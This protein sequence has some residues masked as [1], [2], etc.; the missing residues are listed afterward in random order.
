MTHDEIH[1]RA[2]GAYLGFAIG[3]ALGATVAFMTPAEIQH[4]YGMHRDM[5]GGGWFKLEPGQITDGAQMALALGQSIIDSDGWNVTATADAFAAW[6]KSKPVDV[7]NTCRLGIQR[8]I[9]DGTLAGPPNEDDHGNGACMRNL[10]LALATLHDD[11]AFT[12]ATREQCHLT[13]HH[14]LSDAATLALGR[15]THALIRGG[16]IKGCRAEANR[17]IGA[18]PVF[19]FDPYPKRASGHIV[20]SVQT[21]LYAFFRSDS[22]ESCVTEVVN[23]GEDAATN[24]ALGGML[25]GAAYGVAGIPAYW[26]KKLDKSIRRGI[27]AQTGA[28]LRLAQM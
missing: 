22:F 1:Q 26:L 8:Y 9:T 15:M 12:R 3:D 21:V 25:A 19:R 6:F 17:L 11:D 20:E 18:F 7:G 10:P 2:L 27:E 13:H 23:H 14:P 4:R 16:G 5:V 24:G 28:L